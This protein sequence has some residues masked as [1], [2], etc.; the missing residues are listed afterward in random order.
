[1]DA[2]FVSWG[3]HMD[4]HMTQETWTTWESRMHI[5]IVE[6]LAV[7]KACQ[8][9]LPFIRSHHVLIMSDKPPLFSTSTQGG[10][11]FEIDRSVCRS[12]QP[13]ELL[14]HPPGPLGCSLSLRD[15]EHDCG[16][17]QQAVCDQP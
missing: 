7:W 12:H 17:S 2:S 10:L 11:G 1:M 15:T 8:A 13:L 5:N 6:L 16:L 14:Y 9:F 4:D 3:A